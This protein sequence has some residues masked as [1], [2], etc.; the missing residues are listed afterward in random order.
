MNE[1]LAERLRPKTLDQYLSQTHLIGEKGAL[2]QQIK[3]GIIP[4]MIFWGPPGVGK[5]TLANIIANE[6]DR[7]FFTLSAISSGVKDVREVIEKAKRS[8]GLFT[9]KSPIL[10]I[11]EI[12]RFSKSQQDSL[13]GAVEKGWVTLIGATTENPSFEVISALLSRC[14]VYVLKPFSKEDLIALLNRAM[15][16]DKIIASKNIKLKETEAILRLSGG[17]ARKLLNIFELLVNSSDEGTEITNDM[18]FEKVQQNTVL[19]DKTGEQHYDIISAFIKS[20]RGSDPNGAVYWLARMIEGGEDVKFIARRMLILA[21]EDIGNANPTAL[22]I[23]N[24]TFQ[25]VNTIGYPEARIILS[26]CAT[27]LATSPKS[28]AAYEAIGKALSLV[29]KTGNL[30]VPLEIRN[31]P[32]KLMKDLGYGENYKYAHSYEGNFVKAEFLPDEIRNTI[33]Y[34]PGNNSRENSQREFLKKRWSGKY[35]Y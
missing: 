19:Y 7:P 33:L 16:E 9:T 6:S 12:H 3:R 28:N 26:Q 21:S 14:Q 30:P 27:Y 13:L 18:V 32:T 10:F 8:D 17:D 22:V 29:K 1:P 24:N 35:N 34:E 20:I 4:S 23:A 31:A 2:R 11:D 15:K 5:T 25:A